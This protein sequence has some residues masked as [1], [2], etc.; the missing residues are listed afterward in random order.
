MTRR[1]R[2]R[3]RAA[4]GGR[5]T[6]PHAAGRRCRPP[7]TW[8]L[9]HGLPYFVPEQRAARPRRRCGRGGSCRSCCSWRWSP[10]APA[11]SLALGR[12]RAQRRRRRCWSSLAAGSRPS[13][14]PS[15][16]CTPAR[17][18][19]WALAPHLR[20]PAHAAADDHPRAA[21]AAARSSRSCSSTPRSGRSPPT[22][23]VGA[24]WLA[25]LLFAAAR[26]RRSC[27]CGCPRRSTAP[28]TTSTTQFL[29]ARLPRH[30]AGGG[31]PRAGRGPRRRPG[32]V[33]RGHRL[34]ALE[35]DPRADDR[36]VGP[37]AAA[38][39]VGLRVPHGLRRR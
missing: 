24:L 26:G 23:T 21:A 16:R 8:F 30:A 1:R 20:Q 25:V 13:G 35:P 9:H 36:P 34:R 37:G 31:L 19:A 27:W 12:R 39:A 17:S 14:T 29:L 32:G 22:S 6:R 11:G 18:S 5:V 33:R 7:T 3:P 38:D 2:P 28:T 15:P 10:P 4:G